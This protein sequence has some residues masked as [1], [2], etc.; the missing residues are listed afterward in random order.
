MS[1]KALGKELTVQ[2]E[3]QGQSQHP[4]ERQLRQ[5]TRDSLPPL[6]GVLES[7]AVVLSPHGAAT[8]NTVNPSH[9]IIFFVTS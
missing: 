1:A 2:H 3:V 6:V 9:K 5:H 8:L 4:C 7:R